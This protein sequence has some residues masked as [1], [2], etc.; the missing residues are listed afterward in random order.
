M[1][2][3][4]QASSSSHSVGANVRMPESLTQQFREK[5]EA[6]SP[7]LKND[8]LKSNY[9]SKY[10]SKTTDSAQ[11]RRDRAIEKWLEIEEK[12]AATNERLFSTDAE[13][14]I[15]PRVTYAKFVDWTRRLI[16]ETIGVMPLDDSLI[17]SFSGGAS[18]SRSRTQSHPAQKYLGEAHATASALELFLSLFED[19]MPGWATFADDIKYKIVSGNVLFTVPKK[20]SIDRCACK[21]PDINM[22]LQKGLGN[23]IRAALRTKGINLNDQSKNRSLARSASI[24]Q[25]LATIDLSSAS[26]SVTS[27]LVELLLPEIWFATLDTVR[28]PTTLIDGVEHK[29]EMFSSMGNGFT[30]ELESLLFWALTKATAYFRGVSGVISVYGDDIIAPSALVED[31]M[32]V[33]D[34]FGFSVN[35][36]KSF[37]T[38]SFR[39][40]CGGHYDNGYDITPFYLRAP[41][42]HLTDV[43]HMANSIRLWGSNDEGYGGIIYDTDSSEVYL[44]WNWL[45]S[46]VPKRFWGGRE[47]GDKTRLVTP[48]R[49]KDRLVAVTKTHDTDIGGYIHWLNITSRRTSVSSVFKTYT[50]REFAK[51]AKNVGYLRWFVSSNRI[52]SMCVE[53]SSRTEEFAK[54]RARPVRNETVTSLSPVF[55]AEIGSAE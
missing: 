37:W 8:W 33:L 52:L 25:D 17:G 2:K 32:W 22:F 27:G 18:T 50:G 41:I 10:L 7:S 39:E 43:I 30:F 34:Y 13:F 54:M 46:M 29:N 12:N 11:L 42:M 35:S 31:L 28:S 47:Y 45:K 49:G 51:V 19:E 14:Q 9:L 21:E 5:I 16:E 55:L 3:L 26:D 53:S 24:T 20:T 44:L 1:I 38:G 36:E 15:L 4:V 23:H 48:H 40:S 6:L